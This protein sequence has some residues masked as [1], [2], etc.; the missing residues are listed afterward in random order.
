MFLFKNYCSVEYIQESSKT[1][2]RHLSYPNY[3]NVPN[4]IMFMSCVFRACAVQAIKLD[5]DY[6][7]CLYFTRI[8][9]PLPH[10]LPPSPHFRVQCLLASRSSS[11]SRHSTNQFQA[12]SFGLVA[13]RPLFTEGFSLSTLFV[14]PGLGSII[15]KQ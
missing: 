5:V 8:Y 2:L 4:K 15:P 3:E 9:P 11:T 12:L 10:A 14:N 13:R 1:N 6:L 7:I